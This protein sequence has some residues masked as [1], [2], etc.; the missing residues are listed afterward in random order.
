MFQ[1]VQE[2]LLWMGQLLPFLALN[3]SQ[4]TFSYSTYEGFATHCGLFAQNAVIPGVTVHFSQYVAAGTNLSLEEN[5]PSCNVSHYIVQS[6]ICRV[7]MSVPTSN[8]S[9]MSVEAWFP[10]DYADRYLTTT[11]RGM[12]IVQTWKDC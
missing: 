9:Q 2:A 1:P 11:N 4:H 6:D 3:G 5:H 12:L 7:A 8:E 10:Y